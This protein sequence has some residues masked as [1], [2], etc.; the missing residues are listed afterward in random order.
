MQMNIRERHGGEGRA[1]LQRRTISDFIVIVC[2]LRRGSLRRRE[3]YPWPGRGGA[4]A[5]L[6]LSTGKS[7]GT[8]WT[9]RQPI[10]GQHIGQTTMHTPIHA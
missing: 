10:A 3:F 8:A 7:Q 1:T 5:Y 4:G 6:Q 2:R 9:G